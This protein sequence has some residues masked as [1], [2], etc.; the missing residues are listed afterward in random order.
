[1]IICAIIFCW[2][3]LSVAPCNYIHAYYMTLISGHWLFLLVRCWGAHFVLHAHTVYVHMNIFDDSHRLLLVLSVR[4][5]VGKIIFS[6]HIKAKSMHTQRLIYFNWMSF[7]AFVRH[8][9][10]A[11]KCLSGNSCDNGPLNCCSKQAN[12]YMIITIIVSEH[13]KFE[14]LITSTMEYYTYI[15][16]VWININVMWWLCKQ[17]QIPDYLDATKWQWAPIQ[18]PFSLQLRTPLLRMNV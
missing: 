17:R 1:M 13:G 10:C 6:Q 3:S 2:R 9:V 18:W 12:N 15:H 8:F 16:I 11:W 14:M 5:R 4:F 7:I